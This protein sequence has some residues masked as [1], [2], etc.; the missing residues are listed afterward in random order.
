MHAHAR[1]HT[2]THTRTQAHTHTHQTAEQGFNE[3]LYLHL[4]RARASTRHK[5]LRPHPLSPSKTPYFLLHWM[6]AAWTGA[7][8][9]LSFTLEPRAA[10]A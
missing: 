1:T 6:Q 7:G 5:F 8:R 10:A 3:T 2:R 9:Q 4:T